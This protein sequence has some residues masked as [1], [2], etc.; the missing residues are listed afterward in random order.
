M[1]LA[2]GQNKSVFKREA[3]T[4]LGLLGDFG[5]FT[6]AVILIFGIFGSFYSRSMF[7]GAIAQELPYQH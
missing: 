2:M 5:G 3:Y 7:T 4:I 6:D 1:W